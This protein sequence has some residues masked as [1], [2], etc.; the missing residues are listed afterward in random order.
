M[1]VTPEERR[2]M[3]SLFLNTYYTEHDKG[4]LICAEETAVLLSLRTFLTKM[5][6]TE[7]RAPFKKAP[8]DENVILGILISKKGGHFPLRKNKVR[9]WQSLRHKKGACND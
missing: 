8:N 1:S 7:S 9:R 6:I 5:G 4:F 3:L 2:K